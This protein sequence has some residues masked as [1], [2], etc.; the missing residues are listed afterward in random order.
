[1]PQFPC[2]WKHCVFRICLIEQYYKCIPSPNWG[3]SDFGRE[4]VRINELRHWPKENILGCQLG[5]HPHPVQG[6]CTHRLGT[7][8]LK[9][10][11]NQSCHSPPK[12]TTPE[13][14]CSRYWSPFSALDSEEQ[15]EQWLPWRSEPFITAGLFETPTSL[16]PSF[17]LQKSFW[18][19]SMS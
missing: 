1:M 15:P 8:W 16:C 4:L 5:K 10:E 7:K 13:A 18:Q 17:N 14:V 9:P 3:F 2:L 19:Q 12:G 6:E 11:P